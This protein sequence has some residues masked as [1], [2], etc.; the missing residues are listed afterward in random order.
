MLQ[1]F[2][3]SDRATQIELSSV[4][5]SEA[6]L[7]FFLFLVPFTLSRYD[8]ADLIIVIH[9]ININPPKFLQKSYSANISED[10]AVGKSVLTVSATDADS[11]AIGKIRYEVIRDPGVFAL[12]GSLDVNPE[13]GV[14]FVNTSLDRDT[15]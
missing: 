11:L 13:T 1:K 8:Q 10:L 12:G 5:H 6:F 4:K 9:Q 14:V 2:L 7:F 3:E 15:R